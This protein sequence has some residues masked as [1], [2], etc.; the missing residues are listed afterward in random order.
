MP[1]GFSVKD[2]IIADIP[3]LQELAS[4][5]WH[6]HYPDI[7]TVEQINYML[8][9][10]YSTA[11][12]TAE[13]E[14]GKATWLLLMMGDNAVGF[15]SFGPFDGDTFKLHKLYLD[16]GLHGKG[17][18]SQALKEIE[19]LARQ[20]GAAAIILN[21]NKYNQKAIASYQR[22]GYQVAESVVNDIGHGFV[23]DD[24]VMRKSL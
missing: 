21:V 12:I 19:P 10:G 16:V 22:N 14:N 8:A 13:M 11:R 17:L 7:I 2:A 9:D 5:I 6:D 18:G 24:F 20:Q 15:A 3:L 1:H 23:M 4:R